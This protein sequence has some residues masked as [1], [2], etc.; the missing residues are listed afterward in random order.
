M[1]QI[2]LKYKGFYSKCLLWGRRMLENKK[3]HSAK[4]VTW[5]SDSGVEN[6]LKQHEVMINTQLHKRNNDN[7]N[8]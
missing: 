6:S 2:Q 7:I 4:D 5:E 1:K 3:N 8:S